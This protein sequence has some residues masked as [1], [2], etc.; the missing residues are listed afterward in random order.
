MGH[1][2]HPGAAKNRTPESGKRIR[3]F[4]KC[5]ILLT[6][7]VLVADDMRSDFVLSENPGL[8]MGSALR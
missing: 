4:S 7:K 1:L 6:R 5:L 8:T 3:L 2:P